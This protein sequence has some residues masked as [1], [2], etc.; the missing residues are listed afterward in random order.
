MD[1]FM[2][3]NNEAAEVVEVEAD[4]MKLDLSQTPLA[5]QFLQQKQSTSRGNSPPK[6]DEETTE[7]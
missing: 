2:L 6:E 3:T 5:K 1:N 4:V 7:M